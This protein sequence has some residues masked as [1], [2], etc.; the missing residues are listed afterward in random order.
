MKYSIKSSN[1]KKQSW[2]KMS[3]MLDAEMPVAAPAKFAFFKKWYF[4]LLGGLI[5]L[6]TG[7]FLGRTSVA[8]TLSPETKLNEEGAELTQVLSDNSTP[9]ANSQ[10]NPRN[11]LEKQQLVA[12]YSHEH[13]VVSN[14]VA[15]TDNDISKSKP[16]P[17]TNINTNSKLSELSAHRQP[18]KEAT[19]PYQ[20]QKEIE[21]ESSIGAVTTSPTSNKKPNSQL[22]AS[23]TRSLP[24]EPR[25]MAASVEVKAKN[26]TTI[27]NEES[28]AELTEEKG[29]SLAPQEGAPSTSVVL[30]ENIAVD[31]S[32]TTMSNALDSAENTTPPVLAEEPTSTED[33]LS[34]FQTRKIPS[35]YR[36]LNLEL[37]ATVGASFVVGEPADYYTQLTLSKGIDNRLFLGASYGRTRF[38]KENFADYHRQGSYL[39]SGWGNGTTEYQSRT[40]EEEWIHISKIEIDQI[41]LNFQYII[42]KRFTVHAALI[43]S[44]ARTIEFTKNTLSIDSTYK[45]ENGQLVSATQDRIR[46]DNTTDTEWGNS[47]LAQDFRLSP[48]TSYE[49][50]LH[51]NLTRRLAVTG[52]YSF[53]SNTPFANT[54][55]VGS[56]RNEASHQSTQLTAQFNYIKTGLRF[57]I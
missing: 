15:K 56:W 14:Q 24:A 38:R 4:V 5:L 37:A 19:P 52:S 21:A 28:L 45:R 13:D 1:L 44:R 31:T 10:A 50:G 40:W 12:N 16:T 8:P 46:Q 32:K 18:V 51:F 33:N 17:T 3:K 7:Y 20:T 26:R 41:G 57:R 47:S 6:G 39:N 25:E 34:K 36:Q 11:N 22:P 30:D 49:F 53:I 54:I 23:I 42:N 9:Y 2:N 43:N 29:E 27:E 55:A 35:L 48:F